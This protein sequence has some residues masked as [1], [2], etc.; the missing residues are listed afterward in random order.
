MQ[1]GQSVQ[2]TTQR[3]PPQPCPELWEYNL[4]DMSDGK[5]LVHVVV[6]GSWG[7]HVFFIPPAAAVEIGTALLALG[8]QASSNLILPPGALNGFGHLPEAGPQP[9]PTGG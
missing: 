3:I 4:V 9:P 2:V 7:Q 8:H 1:P 5:R 6:H